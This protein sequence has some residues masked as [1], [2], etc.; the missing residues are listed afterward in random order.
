MSARLGKNSI[1]AARYA[2]ALYELA[3]KE[4]KVKPIEEQLKLFLQMLNDVPDFKRFIY[5]PILVK[6]EKVRA[7]AALSQ[8]MR[9]E[10]LLVNLLKVLARNGRLSCLSQI[11]EAFFALTQASRGEI[12]ARV[13]CTSALRPDQ[14]E[15]LKDLIKTVSGKK[16][17]LEKQIRPSLLGGLVLFFGSYQI[18]TS[19]ASQLSSLKFVLKEVH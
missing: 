16:A 9:V 8:K 17:V 3:H 7:I 5:S 2:G 18:D 14:E 19:L 13:I 6:E 12:Q 10:S 4:G 11:I 1:V 15:S